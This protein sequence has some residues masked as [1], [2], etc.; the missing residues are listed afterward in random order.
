MLGV[1]TLSSCDNMPP[2]NSIYDGVQQERKSYIISFVYEIENATITLNDKEVKEIY[3]DWR[4]KI[5]KDNW[6]KTLPQAL[7]QQ[8][9]I[10]DV[11]EKK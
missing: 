7:T 1:L 4:H 5:L 3:S 10:S 2:R 6:D 11:K 9:I 8:N